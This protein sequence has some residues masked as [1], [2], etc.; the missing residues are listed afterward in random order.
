MSMHTISI[1]VAG[2]AK[3]VVGSPSAPGAVPLESG[4]SGTLN[5]SGRRRAR[6]DRRSIEELERLA[7]WVRGWTGFR[8]SDQ[9][10]LCTVGTGPFLPCTHSLVLALLEASPHIRRQVEGAVRTLKEQQP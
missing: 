5:S 3:I 2:G 6:R 1:D 8:L 9:Q 10:T 7:G 4:V